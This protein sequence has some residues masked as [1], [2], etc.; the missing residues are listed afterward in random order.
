MACLLSISNLASNNLSYCPHQN[1]NQ[2]EG[3]RITEILHDLSEPGLAHFVEF[4]VV[5]WFLEHFVPLGVRWINPIGCLFSSKHHK[6]SG[7]IRVDGDEVPSDP[8][9]I[10]C[11]SVVWSTKGVDYLLGVVPSL[12]F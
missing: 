7:C 1:V 6:L 12:A 2:D 4:G 11:N 5:A 9:E 8:K 3:I 10:F